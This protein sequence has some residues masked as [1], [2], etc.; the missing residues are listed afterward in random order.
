M[1]ELTGNELIFRFP[2]VHEDA[3]CKIKFMRTLRIPDDNK[4]YPLPAGL[5]VF[6]M[7]HVE[8][9]AKKLPESWAEKGGVLLPM[10]QAEAMWI[11]FTS[12]TYYP[13]AVKI[14]AGKINAVT[15]EAWSEVLESEP[16]DYVVLPEQLWLDGFCVDKGLIRQFVAMPLGGGYTAEE[17]LSQSTENGGLQI[18][19]YP[20]K[21]GLYLK[22]LQESCSDVSYSIPFFIGNSPAN[23]SMGLAAGGLMRQEIREDYEGIKSWDTEVSKRCFIHILNSTQW[24]NATGLPRINKP[25]TI[26]EYEKQGI[27]WFEHYGEPNKVLNGS[28]LLAGLDSI[29]AKA[30][31]LGHGLLQNNESIKPKKIISL[32]SM[33]K[34]VKDG[35]W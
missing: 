25:L 5:G 7:A 14:A 1:V 18:T 31:K 10:Y 34:S 9:H 33:V 27:P 8:D 3:V 30:V 35:F 12:S 23:N 19:V 20:M 6:P 16:Q 26:K 11:R 29:A 13:F 32:S 4:A 2:D 17:Q 21:R 24:S 28:A 22:K 15:G